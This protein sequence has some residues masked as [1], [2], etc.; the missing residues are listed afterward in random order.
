MEM[1]WPISVDSDS[2]KGV[3]CLSYSSHFTFILTN[4]VFGFLAVHPTSEK[5]PALDQLPSDS[6]LSINN[7]YQH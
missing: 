1:L 7:I 4:L 2:V 5:V 3:A 6:L